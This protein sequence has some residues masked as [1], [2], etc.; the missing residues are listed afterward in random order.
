MYLTFPGGAYMLV[1]TDGPGVAVFITGVFT[2]VEL[3]N[4]K[5][6]KL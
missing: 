4:D 6:L 3:F 1:G 2:T 5:G